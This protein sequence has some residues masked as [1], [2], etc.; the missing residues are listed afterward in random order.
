MLQ[1]AKRR[2]LTQVQDS[3]FKTECSI[4]LCDMLEAHQHEAKLLKREL[5]NIIVDSKGTWHTDDLS[6]TKM[7]V[8]VSDH[9]TCM[10]ETHCLHHTLQ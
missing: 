7:L 1:A 2:P 8:P 9:S 10:D 5:M 3:Q 4:Q 6:S